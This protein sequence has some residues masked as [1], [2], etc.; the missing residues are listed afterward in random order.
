MQENKKIDDNKTCSF[1]KAVFPL[2]LL[3]NA[4]SYG[5]LSNL[6]EQLRPKRLRIFFFI[7]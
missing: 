4:V 7:I 6:V 1:T 5:T 2:P 3:G